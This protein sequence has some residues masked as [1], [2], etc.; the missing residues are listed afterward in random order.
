[1]GRDN[2]FGREKRFFTGDFYSIKIN[3]F[4]GNFN[5]GLV[6][7]CRVGKGLVGNFDGGCKYFCIVGKRG[8]GQDL[9]D[10]GNFT[11]KFYVGSDSVPFE[12]SKNQIINIFKIVTVILLYMFRMLSH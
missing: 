8:M 3:N 1:M 9:N 7:F 12:N 4:T 6:D 10:S 2:L 5:G 11:G